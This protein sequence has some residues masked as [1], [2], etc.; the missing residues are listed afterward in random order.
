MNAHE[1]RPL[2]AL[3]TFVLA[4][5]PSCAPFTAPAEAR[6]EQARH[7]PGAQCDD[8]SPADRAAQ[9]LGLRGLLDVAPLI[10]TVRKY[11]G[12]EGSRLV[13]VE[14]RYAAPPGVTPMWLQRELECHQADVVLGRAPARPDDPYV[15]PDEWLALDVGAVGSALVVQVSAASRGAA[16]A[17]VERARRLY[18]RAQVR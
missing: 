18:A 14:I 12:M 4:C 15:A 17:S 13:G 3:F 8:A 6:I 9:V 11:K 10:A 16:T 7:V 1:L 2:A 5:A